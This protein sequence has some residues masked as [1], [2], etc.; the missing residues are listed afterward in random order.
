MIAIVAKICIEEEKEHVVN[1]QKHSNHV[2]HFAFTTTRAL[3]TSKDMQHFYGM[4]M[5]KVVTLDILRENHV[6][7]TSSGC[8]W[9]NVQAHRPLV[10]GQSIWWTS[11]VDD[12]VDDRGG[13]LVGRH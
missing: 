1:P 6:C 9:T 10:N 4:H 11:K 3:I 7:R 8:I 2:D 13:W 5:I 12:K